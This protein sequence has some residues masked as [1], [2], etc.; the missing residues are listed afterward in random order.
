MIPALAQIFCLKLYVKEM[1]PC[2]Y[3]NGE[4]RCGRLQL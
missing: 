2:L 3:L 1:N 4:V